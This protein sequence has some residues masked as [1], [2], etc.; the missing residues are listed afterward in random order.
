MDS[1]KEN[2]NQL[3]AMYEGAQSLGQRLQKEEA[4]GT[5][6]LFGDDVT[7]EETIEVPDLP[8]LP[9]EE[10]LRDEKEY[11]GFYITG[12]PLNAFAEE[13][14]GLFELGKLNDNPEQ[15]DGQT[16]VIGGLIVE[17]SDK[18]TRRNDIMSVIR[19]EDFSGS[20]AA[21]AFPQ[22]FQQSQAYLAVDMAVRITGRIDAD[23]KGVQIIADSVK[24]LKVNY[25]KAKQVIIHIRPGF[26]TAEASNRL[27]KV[28]LETDGTV[29][30][31][32]YLHRQRKRIDVAKE[33]FIQPGTQ[34]CQA[35]EKILG[36]DSVEIM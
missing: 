4:R 5:M 30:V 34:I 35:I 33:Y 32:F 26:D 16:V 2:R 6:S 29:P 1:F 17:K 15:Y 19:V 18:V 25:E 14:N 8:D 12:H 10:K 23:E 28:L 11:T 13:L 3:L 9:S 24:P 22:V 31:S 36:P 27:K 20:A 7:V 21:V